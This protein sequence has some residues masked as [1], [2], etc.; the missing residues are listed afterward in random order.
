MGLVHELRRRLGSAVV[1]DGRQRL[2]VDLDEL[3]RVLGEV[4]VVGD[5]Q[6]DRVADEAHLVLG[7]RRTRRLR[8]PRPDRRVPLLLRR[9]GLRSAAV[10]TARTPGAAS[11]ADV[12]MPRIAARAN[13]LRTKHACSIP[14]SAMSST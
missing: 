1:D 7:Q 5:D 8:T 6:R 3:G 12:S 2:V 4:A 10:N 13:G 9:R 14:G 11:A